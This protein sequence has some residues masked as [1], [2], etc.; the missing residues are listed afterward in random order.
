[1]TPVQ[2]K[3][4]AEA[5]KGTNIT[6]ATGFHPGGMKIKCIFEK[7]LHWNERNLCIRVLDY[8]KITTACAS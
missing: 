1:M 4:Y 2:W 5:L 7:L 8:S 3:K 6:D